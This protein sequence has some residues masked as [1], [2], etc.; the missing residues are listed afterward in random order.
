V[1]AALLALVSTGFVATLARRAPLDL[2]VERNASSLYQTAADGRI[3][4]AY[5]LHVQNRDRREHV[6]QIALDAPH[7]YELVAGVNPLR[8]PATGTLEARVFV[9]IDQEKAEG[10]HGVA[11][12][13]VLEQLEP[14]G[15][16]IVRGSTFLRPLAHHE[17]GEER[18]ES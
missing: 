9:L 2:Q 14:P 3:S 10:E 7:G 4:N 18:D 12:R 13:F 8:I 6:Y 11:I 1:Y 17:G 16:R 5:T 15:R